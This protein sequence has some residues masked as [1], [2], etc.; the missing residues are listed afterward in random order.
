MSSPGE[1]VILDLP[2]LD[3]SAPGEHWLT[4]AARLVVAT[5]WAQAGHTDGSRITVRQRIAA[6]VHS[7]AV[8]ATMRWTWLEG[9]RL[10]PSFSTAWARVPVALM[11]R[12]GTSCGRGRSR[13]RCSCKSP[14][15]QGGIAPEKALPRLR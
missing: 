7:R 14:A 11:S 8:L 10:D 12:P 5:P 6:A 4:V 2:G 1:F 3:T 13:C 9:L 15:E